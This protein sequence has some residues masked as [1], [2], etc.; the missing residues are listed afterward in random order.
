[1][2]QDPRESRTRLSWAEMKARR[3]P[4]PI[5]L[6]SAESGLQPCELRWKRPIEGD[7][8]GAVEIVCMAAGG[9]RLAVKGGDD[10]DM[11]A[12]CGSCTIPSETARRPCLYLVPIKMERDHTVRDYFI[13]RWF[14]RLRPEKPATTTSCICDGC[15][16]WFPRPP[17]NLLKDYERATHKI[18][19]YHEDA[20]AGRLP[21][22]PLS[23]WTK[24]W[25]PAVPRWKRLL[26]PFLNLWLG[27]WCLAQPKSRPGR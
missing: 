22:S 3:D 25:P 8:S 18:I 20:W 11:L 24:H 26:R 5:S 4:A 23:A 15:P 9:K 19:K 21:P 6:P 2:L 27:W 1:M 17:L 7:G 13:C 16:Y 14:Y 10:G 12:T